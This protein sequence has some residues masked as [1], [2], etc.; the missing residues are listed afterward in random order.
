M[1]EAP[2][3]ILIAEDNAALASVM[4][5]NLERA[6]FRVTV[7]RSG[8]EAWE[9]VCS[10]SFDLILTDEQMPEM[11]GREFCKQLRSRTESCQI[12]VIMLTAKAL[13][14]DTG[15]LREELGIETVFVKPFS[16]REVIRAVQNRLAATC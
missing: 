10:R 4:R 12:P 1:N 15:Q 11:G 3:N 9:Q 16:P 13:E 2:G 14:I 5:F 8:R 7:A 6:G